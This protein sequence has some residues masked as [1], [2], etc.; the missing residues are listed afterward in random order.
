MKRLIGAGILII[1]LSLSPSMGYCFGND[2]FGETRFGDKSGGVE[3]VLMLAINSNLSNNGLVDMYPSMSL[4][5]N[6]TTE[7]NVFIDYAVSLALQAIS[8]L[9]ENNILDAYSALLLSS[10]V[11]SS[12]INYVDYGTVLTLASQIALIENANRDMNPAL[13]LSAISQ[14][15]GIN[16]AEYPSAISLP[17]STAIVHTV[18]SIQEG[19]IN[20]IAQGNIQ[21][22]SQ[23]AGFGSL[24]LETV[25]W[26]LETNNVDWQIVLTLNNQAT[27]Y[28]NVPGISIDVDMAL[29]VI[30]Q[31]FNAEN[32]TIETSLSL[33]ISTDIV[34]VASITRQGILNLVSQI[35]LN[36]ATQLSVLGSL[37]LQT[38]AQTAQGLPSNIVEGLVALSL[39]SQ[40]TNQNTVIYP[41]TIIFST[42]A[43][44]AQ[45][46][47]TVIKEGIVNL[48]AQGNIS[49]ATQLAAY[50][51]LILQNISQVGTLTNQNINI[52]AILSAIAHAVLT[53]D[54]GKLKQLVPMGGG[55][56]DKG[57]KVLP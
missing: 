41:T 4:S 2:R 22:A 55:L 23:L 31:I 19:V 10:A 18:I 34:D 35:D 32:L 56:F 17:I 29:T 9:E 48:I 47:S 5:A 43:A 7:N 21:E 49:S 15:I 40:I 24:L 39:I 11:L 25:T 33:P 14:L 42:N 13:I 46:L 51:G 45:I 53:G 16:Y 20:L 3:G 1:F 8:S 54:T 44:M 37:L 36:T 38:L 50:G 12:N 26:A 27:Q 6:T 57:K 52:T 30:S 28:Q